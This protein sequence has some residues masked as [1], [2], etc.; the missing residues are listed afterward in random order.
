M[1]NHPTEHHNKQTLHFP[2][3]PNWSLIL[4]ILFLVST[5]I[6][7]LTGD[8]P[9]ALRIY[10]DELLYVSLGRSLLHSQELQIHSLDSNFQ[11]IL[12]SLCTIP[13]FLFQ[14]TITQIRTVG[15]INSLI[16]STS[17]F[18]VYK[19]SRSLLGSNRKTGFILAF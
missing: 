6:R 5:V 10:P 19:L 8:F 11:K 16:V 1:K 18:P 9:K 4:I 13:A 3:H 14:S 17:V 7:G 15:Y 2:A 12:Y